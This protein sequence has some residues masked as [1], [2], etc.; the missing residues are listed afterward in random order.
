[1]EDSNIDIT[2]SSATITGVKA[3][4][5]CKEVQRCKHKQVLSANEIMRVVAFV[6]SCWLISLG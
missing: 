1:M 2:L 5:T 3:D 4:Y 6:L